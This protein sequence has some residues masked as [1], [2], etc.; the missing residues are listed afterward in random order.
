MPVRHQNKTS[1]DNALLRYHLD[2]RHIIQ[3][4][5]HKHYVSKI[6]FGLKIILCLKLTAKEPVVD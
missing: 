5:L 6:V 1:G 4:Q 3:I 2:S